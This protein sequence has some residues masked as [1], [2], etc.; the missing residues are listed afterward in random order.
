MS[1]DYNHKDKDMIIIIGLLFS[2]VINRQID[3]LLHTAFRVTFR[4]GMDTWHGTLVVFLF[5]KRVPIGLM[6]GRSQ[7]KMKME[8][9]AYECQ[10][11]EVKAP[12]HK[13]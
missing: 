3:V 10:E 11:G 9:K 6:N 7:S 2:Q 1:D 4:S 13:S 12:V 5:I 8:K